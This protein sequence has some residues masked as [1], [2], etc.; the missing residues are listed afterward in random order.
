MD[1]EDARGEAAAAAAAA[2]GRSAAAAEHAGI[3][4]E[5]VRMAGA[6]ADSAWVRWL[7]L[8]RWRSRGASSNATA[9]AAQLTTAGSAW[10]R[11]L[12]RLPGSSWLWDLMELAGMSVRRAAG[13]GRRSWPRSPHAARAGAAGSGH[14]PHP[15]DLHRPHHEGEVRVGHHWREAE[16]GTHEAYTPAGDTG[17]QIVAST[18]DEFN[19]AREPVREEDIPGHDAWWQSWFPAE[20]PHKRVPGSR[21]DQQ[22]TGGPLPH[23]VGVHAA[24]PY[25]ALEAEWEGEAAAVPGGKPAS[26]TGGRFGRQRRHPL[27]GLRHYQAPAWTRAQLEDDAA[28]LECMRRVDASAIHNALPVRRGFMFYTGEC[29]CGTPRCRDGGCRIQ[30]DH[31]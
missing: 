21:Y 18:R 12:A 14:E 6:E 22:H 11:T 23:Q 8:E 4:G 2:A 10:Q 26:G 1:A 7:G 27:P 3:S 24:L 28:E 25:P 9:A 19:A 20:R 16:V 30:A 17:V 13:G 29:E 15:G 5:A 31:S